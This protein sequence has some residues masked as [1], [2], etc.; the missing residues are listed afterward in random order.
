MLKSEFHTMSM[1]HKLFWF[2][3]FSNQLKSIIPFS[4]QEP[5][6]KRQKANSAVGHSWQLPMYK[7]VKKDL[8]TET[9]LHTA[10]KKLDS[11]SHVY[12]GTEFL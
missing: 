2:L 11:K 7:V 10:L 5:F 1:C 3:F 4:A 12:L 9:T 8:S 6:R